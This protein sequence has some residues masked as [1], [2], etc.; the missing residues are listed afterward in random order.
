MAMIGTL[1]RWDR[2]V[3]AVCMTLATLATFDIGAQP[4]TQNFD[5]V[6]ALA[7][8]GWVVTNNS[9][10]VG[11]TGWFQGNG[12]IFPA[13]AGAASSYIGANFLNAGLAGNVSNWLISPNLPGLQ[14]G[15]TLTFY[16]RSAGPTPDRLEVR[17]CLGA[18]CTNVGATDASVGTFTTLLLTVNPTQIA[19]AYPNAW[20][21]YTAVLSGLPA[22]PNQ[23]RIAFRYFITGTSTNGNYIGIDT[24]TLTGASVAP[25]LQSVASRKVHGGAG[26]FNLPLSL[27]VP[28]TV[29]HNPTTE[30][31]QGPAQTIVFTFDKPVNAGTA[32]VTE[33]AAAIGVL[34]FSGNDVIVP[35]TGVTDQQYVTI[36]VNSVASTDGGTGG[37]GTVRIGFLLG[38]VNASRV[39]TL[40][41][42]G[43]VNAQLAQP[44]TAANYLKDVTAGGTL[45]LP[46]KVI[47]N[48]NLTKSLPT[49]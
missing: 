4:L 17:L 37:T 10:T 39:V 23:G 29:N 13:Q 21:L 36:A 2:A 20:T 30:P 47:T 48:N 16:S 34:S 5:N 14:N 41:D 38:D 46:D 26:T 18:S 43:L 33:G 35:L 8:A 3:R 6:A 9:N 32:S 19:N 31:R 12:A 1:P 40:T 25:V 15:E 45:T 42:V 22:G 27:V 28:P 11:T 24:L 49:P 44:V 7:G